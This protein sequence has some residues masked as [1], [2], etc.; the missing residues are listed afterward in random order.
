MVV[1]KKK[2]VSKKSSRKVRSVRNASSENLNRILVDNFVSLQNVMV[3]NAE[4]MDVLS[5]QMTKLLQIFEVA[6]KSFAEKEFK[7]V[8][9]VAK[10]TEFLG[11]LNTLL[12]Q[13]KTIAKG[14]H[15]LGEDMREKIYGDLPVSQNTPA[16]QILPP[17]PSQHKSR[18]EVSRGPENNEFRS[19][20]SGSSMTRKL[21][22]I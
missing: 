21:P 2:S 4:R 10:D 20:D 14:L 22:K 12:D 9:G 19:S 6:A 11:K 7:A 18:M 16:S 13:N 1:K 5:A 15:L 17:T 3:R 8:G